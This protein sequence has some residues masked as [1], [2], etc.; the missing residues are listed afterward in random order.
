LWAGWRLRF[1]L[2]LGAGVVGAGGGIA[3][4][5]GSC[6]CVGF[7]RFLLLGSLLGRLDRWGWG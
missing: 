6:L 4:A 2:R 3:G 5:R 1:R 7:G